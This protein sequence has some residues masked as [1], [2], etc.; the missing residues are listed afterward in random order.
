MEVTDP[1]AGKAKMRMDMDMSAAGQQI[2]LQMV[3]IDDTAWVEDVGQEKWTEGR[4][5][6]GKSGAPRRRQP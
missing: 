5:R 6:S 2:K 3:M 4:G 1:E